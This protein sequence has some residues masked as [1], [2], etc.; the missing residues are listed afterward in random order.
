[1][2][3]GVLGLSII[4]IILG[5]VDLSRIKKGLSSDEGKILDIVGIVLGCIGL[6]VMAIIIT[7]LIIIFISF[8]M[9]GNF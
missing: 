8:R 6:V 3:T 4:P 5:W 7:S 1:M 9:G 2:V